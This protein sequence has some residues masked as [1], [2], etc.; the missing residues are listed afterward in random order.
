MNSITLR[1]AAPSD[2][3][4]FMDLYRN[5]REHEMHATGW[6]EEQ[7]QQFIAFQ[8]HARKHHY[9]EFYKGAIDEVILDT[10]QPIGRLMIHRSD[11]D[12]LVMLIEL[13]H[14]YRGQGIGTMLMKKIMDDAD[15]PVKLH[16]ERHGGPIHFYEKL[17]FERTGELDL[18][19][20]MMWYPEGTKPEP[21]ETGTE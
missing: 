20:E 3:P 8:Y 11:K 10:G 6:N 14:N 9:S 13:L 2:E 5:T 15:L 12:I 7:R 4:F 19:Y 18:H 1:N 17:G 21:V 16:V